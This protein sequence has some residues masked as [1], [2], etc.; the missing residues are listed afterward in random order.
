M[1]N[2]IYKDKILFSMKKLIFRKFY[3]DISA[4]FLASILIV[5]LIVWTIQAVNY[6]DFVTEEGHGLKIYFYY[7]ILNFPKI[8]QRIFPFIFFIS[9]FYII[10]N[11]E[12]KNEIFIFWINGVTKINF[13]N[14]LLSLSLIFMIIQLILGSYISP[15]SKLE[16]RNYLKN[17][18]VDFF[19]SLIKEGKFINIT[20]GLTI[21]I[22]RKEENGIFRDI[23]LEE[24]KKGSTK[25]IYASSGRLVETESQKILKLFDGKVINF[26]N[27]RINIFEFEQINFS[28]QNLNTKSITVPKIQEI[29]TKI[30]LSCFFDIE[31]NKFIRFDCSEKL[32]KEVKIELIKRLYKPIYIPLIV[33][34]SC[35]LIL[36]SKNQKNYKT[37]INLVFMATFFLLV[38]SEVSIQYS[39]ISPNLTILYL[40]IPIIIFIISYLF[41]YRLVK[42]V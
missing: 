20:K 35:F 19:T 42:N 18:K 16:A 6:F 37:Q 38:Y 40:T 25:M 2:G 14:R 17:S 28:L 27:S 5:G 32:I 15:K 1:L 11:Y 23:F 41:F 3:S 22:D 13:L 9:I 12:L 7:S 33:L 10:L 4:F 31:N 34:F 30:L 29:D 24:N 39:A 36:Y 21:F 26:D 8:I